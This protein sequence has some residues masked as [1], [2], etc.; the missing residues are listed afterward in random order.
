MKS[1]SVRV[2]RR[3]ARAAAQLCD[4]RGD[5]NAVRATLDGLA[6]AFEQAP[7]A[8]AFLAN[9]TFALVDRQQ[10]LEHL[11]TGCA[12]QATARNLLLLLLEKG[13]I[14][15]FPAVRTEFNALL[16]LK[17]GRVDATVT[18]AVALNEAALQRLQGLLQRL[19]GKQVVLHTAVD[20][21]LIGGLVV[22]IGNTVYDSSVANHLARLRQTLTAD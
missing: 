16:D 4:E 7:D 19:V 13:R 8:L 22:R 15:V 5:G 3:Y 6:V 1:G 11:L 21:S 9:P 17:T 10:V 12:A 18:S 20:E 2:A 14:S